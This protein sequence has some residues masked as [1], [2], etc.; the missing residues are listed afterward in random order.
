M[1]F[2]DAPAFGLDALPEGAGEV[3]RALVTV[4]SL[5]GGELYGTSGAATGD[6]TIA[7]GLT[8]TRI[9][10]EPDGTFILNDLGTAA[11][12]AFFGTDGAGKSV[13]LMNA[14]GDAAEADSATYFS[15][16]GSD[17]ATWEL[18]TADPFGAMRTALATDDKLLI[19]LA[20]TG[21]IPLGPLRYARAIRAAAPEDVLLIALEISHPK[22]S[23]PVRVV[24]N[25]VN[26]IIEGNTYVGLRFSARLADDI[27]G[28]APEAELVI[29]NV[30]RDM[31]QWIEAADGGAGATVRIMQVLAG[32]PTAPESEMTLDVARVRAD[33][34][35]IVVGLGFD[36]L[37]GR[38]AVQLRHDPQT[39]PGLF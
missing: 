14:V 30:G 28:R 4:G 39:S 18:G 29:D 9:R 6:L 17:H 5:T 16:A 33:Q 34:E 3:M 7:T 22:I 13:Y 38:G 31:M 11:M 12:S 19:V 2:G 10:W 24:N 25:P 27:E 8:V 32:P 15:A 21:S 20:D 23:D 37:L 36:P 1:T 35:R 26:Q